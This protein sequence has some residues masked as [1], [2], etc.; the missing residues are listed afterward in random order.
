M[1]F[2]SNLEENLLVK[3]EDQGIHSIP[4]VVYTPSPKVEFKVKQGKR[5][6]NTKFSEPTAFFQTLKT[7]KIKADM[8]TLNT[9]Q[10]F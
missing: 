6:T 9:G 4:E 3:I 2:N 8:C 1:Y 10:Y 7:R 5:S